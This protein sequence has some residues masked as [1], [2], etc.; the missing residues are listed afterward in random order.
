MER[1]PPH[2][3]QPGEYASAQSPSEP[4]LFYYPVIVFRPFRL[5][6][7]CDGVVYQKQN[8]DNCGIIYYGSNK[9]TRNHIVNLYPL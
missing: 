8:E 1:G 3:L 6:N 9:C 2:P 7:N 4:I 5:P